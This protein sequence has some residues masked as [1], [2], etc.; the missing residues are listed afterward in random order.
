MILQIKHLSLSISCCEEHMRVSNYFEFYNCE[1]LPTDATIILWI[2]SKLNSFVLS[3]LVKYKRTHSKC[4]RKRIMRK[5]GPETIMFSSHIAFPHLFVVGLFGKPK[6]R[7][8]CHHHDHDS[9]GNQ[10]EP[11]N[12]HLP[13]RHRREGGPLT[14]QQQKQQQQ[15]HTHVQWSL[16]R[17]AVVY[18]H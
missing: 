13:H 11:K 3:L 2:D 1:F 5:R 8:Y 15:Q 17:R 7:A 18:S 6:F 9:P 10:D 14:Q 4:C 16:C 12:K